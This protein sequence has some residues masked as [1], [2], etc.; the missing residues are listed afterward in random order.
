VNSDLPSSHRL[1]D[2]NF[3][4]A[5]LSQIGFVASNTLMAHYGR[6]IGVLGG[7]VESVGWIMG[8]GSMA[9]LILR[10]WCGQWIDRIG[11]RN[12]WL[13]GY[14]LFGIAS[15]GNLTLTSLSNWIYLWRGLLVIGAAFVFSS[16]LAYITQ[17]APAARRTEAIG[18]LGVAGFIG[19]MTGPLV[20]DLLLGEN[21]TVEG[22]HNLFIGA[23]IALVVPALL[24]LGL[25]TRARDDSQPASVRLVDFIRDVRRYW[26]GSIVYV[27][28]IFGLC[29]TVPF[30]FLTKYVDAAHI[31]IEGISEVGLF[32]VCYA[33]WGLT[34]R[35][36]S[37]KIPER[38]GRRKMLLFGGLIMAIGQ[39][40]YFLVD[41]QSPWWIVAPALITGTGHALM[42]HTATS[43]F[44][45]TFPENS[46]GVGSA[47][48][49]MIIDTGMIGGAPIMGWMAA[50][51]GYN[52]MFAAV[53]VAV[54]SSVVVYSWASIPVWKEQLRL[55]QVKAD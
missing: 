14:F 50:R 42:F 52:S 35:I 1:Y 46:R 6:W 3:A 4:F 39:F 33:G 5:F 48:A 47:F 12:M 15:L 13:I 40:S 19:I 45:H 24:L 8:I 41:Q 7:D 36:S 27:Q 2:R 16:S 34:V 23:A 17:V 28:L 10:P 18:S 38:L 49:L 29:M 31:S 53:G 54:L 26:P 44:V 20:G 21:H 37:R 11:A 9:S 32:F 30:V 25:K 43:L 22:F 51:Y 55:A